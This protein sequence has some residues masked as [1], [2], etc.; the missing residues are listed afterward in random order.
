MTVKSSLCYGKVITMDDE[1]IK[2]KGKIALLDRWFIGENKIDVLCYYGRCS[3][4]ATCTEL[5]SQLQPKAL[6]SVRC[7]II[8]YTCEF[9]SNNIT[10]ARSC[11]FTRLLVRSKSAVTHWTMNLQLSFLFDVV[12]VVVVIVYRTGTVLLT[13]IKLV[14]LSEAG[15]LSIVQEMF[16]KQ[17]HYYYFLFI[18]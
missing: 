13:N 8:K 11:S 5:Q 4:V 1:N 18:L 17:A 7:I 3:L 2:L 10:F 9:R 14:L 12:V 16:T 6:I 15:N